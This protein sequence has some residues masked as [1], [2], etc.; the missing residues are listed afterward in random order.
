M[1]EGDLHAK[2][3]LS[4]ANATLGVLTSASLAIHAVGRGLA[5]AMG[6]LTKHGVKQVDR[7]L[8]NRG[9]NV[10]TFFAYWTPYLVGARTEVVVALDW[11]SFAADEQE[12]IVLSMLTGHGRATPLLWKTVASST[13][14]DNQRRYEYEVLC[15]LRDV[16]PDGVK[17]TIVAD[18]G[19]ADCKL[20]YA[21]TTELGFEYVIRLRGDV[22][23]TNASGERRVAAAWVGA[24]GR[25]RRLVGARVT[26]VHEWPVGAVVCVHDQKMDEPWCLVASE[27]TVPTRVLIRYYGKRWGIEAGCRD[28]KDMRFGMG[29]SSMQVSR[30][31][32]RDRL[33]LLSALAIAVLSL[34]G[35]AGERIGYD[36]W[37]KANTVRV[38]AAALRTDPHCLRRLEPTDPA[39]VELRE[40]SRLSEE[41]TRERV[42]LA[43]RM[44]Q[45]LWRYYPQFLDAVD[46]DVAAPWALDLWRSLPTPGA[47]QRVREVTLTR[48]LKQHRIRRVDAATLRA[49]L[50][51]PAV[52]VAAGAAEAAVAHV[53]LLTER[54]ALVNR[55][56]NDVRR[57]L[58]R[59]VRQLA[60]AT[61]ADAADASTEDEPAS[62]TEPPDAA[63]LLSLPGIGTGVL[64]T[65]L[66]EASDVV[67]RRDYDALRCLCGV[68]PVTRRSGKSLIVTRRLA[69]HERLR[70]AAYHWARVAAQRDPVSHAKYQALRTRGHGHARALRSVADRLLNVACAMLRDGA[71]FD[72]HR[73]GIATT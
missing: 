68:A 3:V 49:R 65:L 31:D 42:R 39:I 43:N 61:P 1:Y 2:R 6:T 47:G 38:L 51:A 73:V 15:R 17:V 70:D 26:D 36:R 72:P 40:W 27:A 14:K 24:G 67:Q 5:Q 30:P 60:E 62:S 22:Y 66:A 64:A 63:I 7:L 18:R 37:L 45:Q 10:W 57:E 29:L 48:V 33:L 19:F 16:L 28:I 34:L 4:L 35:A 53:R 52:K 41:L 8:S 54:L 23:V 59:L 9:I 46:D 58:V 13:L 71:C 20:F 12:T 44:R 21:L 69:T 55:Q 25:A 50:R 11:T 56:L 32:R